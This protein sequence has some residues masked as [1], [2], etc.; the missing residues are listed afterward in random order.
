MKASIFVAV[1]KYADSQ[2]IQ[3]VKYAEADARRFAAV[4]EQHGFAP[5]DRELLIGGEATKTAIESALRTTLKP[6]TREDTIYLFYSGHGLS[7]AGENYLTCHDTRL[8]DLENTSLPLRWL[9]EQLGKSD[10]RRIVLFLDACSAVLL[11][12]EELRKSYDNLDEAELEVFFESGDERVCFWSSQGNE[13]SHASSE[14]KHRIW[15][16]HVIQAFDGQNPLALQGQQLTCASLQ[17]YLSVVIPATL[18]KIDPQGVQTPRKFG[19]T[20]KDFSLADLEEVTAR[21]KATKHPQAGQVKDSV[22]LAESIVSVKSFPGFI[23]GHS[24]PDRHDSRARLFINELASTDIQEDVERV[25]AALKREFRFTRLQLSVKNHGEGAATVTTP[26]FN[27]N[28]SVEQAPQDP[29][30]VLWKRTVDAIKD[31]ERI[32][33]SQF[34][35]VF[36]K[37]F[38]TVELSLHDHLNLDQLIDTI[39]AIGSDEIEVQYDEDE[40]ITSCVVAIKGYN[41]SIHVTANSFSI[42]HPKLESPRLL[43]QS[44]FDIQLALTEKHHVLVIPFESLD[45]DSR[46]EI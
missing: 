43:L 15:S 45:G 32:L 8:S 6:L 38:D 27:Y 5:S 44:L 17:S 37:T 26:Y 42:V 18:K 16:H 46:G 30:S 21:R 23:K 13:T 2:K 24:V 12:N 19:A 34:E 20:K 25:R 39:E 1:E 29:G 22:L 4:L 14:G 10:C 33:S 36:A 9:F 31:P 41:V 40:G 11:A 28:V 35:A 3:E 7:Q